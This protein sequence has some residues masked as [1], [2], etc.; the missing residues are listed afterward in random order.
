M[1]WGFSTDA[2]GKTVKNAEAIQSMGDPGGVQKSALEK[3]NEQAGLADTSKRNA[4]DQ[5]KVLVP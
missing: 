3:W 1:S 5:E 2:A 4:P